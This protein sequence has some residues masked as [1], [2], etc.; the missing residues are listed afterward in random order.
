MKGILSLIRGM[1]VES[2]LRNG[3]SPQ[4]AATRLLL[5][6]EADAN[7]MIMLPV[8]VIDISRQLGL[9]Y[10]VLF[11][12]NHV[13]GLL[14]KE[15]DAPLFK[16]VVD[17]GEPEEQTRFVLAHELGHFVH[18]FRD[19]D[20]DHREVG[21]VEHHDEL[22]FDCLD[23]EER[24][25]SEFAVSLLTPASIVMGFW[26]DGL[27]VGEMASRFNVTESIMRHRIKS[28]GLR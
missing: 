20:W 3:P 16:A 23:P 1:R 7:G 13:D 15:L 19:G 4:E 9:D 28:L 27:S 24:W 21:L 6:I 22:G 14:V 17:A 26:A 5:E 12:Q 2:I 10:M 11:L 8:N 25:A 18:S